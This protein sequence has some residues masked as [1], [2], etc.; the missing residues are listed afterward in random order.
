MLTAAQERQ[1]QLERLARRAR[2]LSLLDYCVRRNQL[3]KLLKI[4]REHNPSKYE[5]IL[6]Q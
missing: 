1:E 2:M 3:D 5:E 4:V 6:S